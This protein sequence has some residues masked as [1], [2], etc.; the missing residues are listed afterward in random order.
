VLVVMMM[1]MMSMSM[2]MVAAADTI[3]LRGG[4][5]VSVMGA[6]IVVRVMVMLMVAIVIV[7]VIMFRVSINPMVVALDVVAI[8]RRCLGSFALNDKRLQTSDAPFEQ[9]FYL[10]DQLLWCDE[11]LGNSFN[12]G[13]RRQSVVCFCCAG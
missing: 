4:V 1:M 6:V 12:R 11:W 5:L 13:G 10:R 3:M 9:C 2:M 7:R 8:G